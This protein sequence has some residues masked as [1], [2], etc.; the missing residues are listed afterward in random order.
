MTDAVCSGRL[1]GVPVA[2]DLPDVT[3]FLSLPCKMPFVF[4]YSLHFNFL[5]CVMITLFIFYAFFAWWFSWCLFVSAWIFFLFYVFYLRTFI[6]LCC[7]VHLFNWINISMQICSLLH[8]CF[9]HFLS[10]GPTCC[11]IQFF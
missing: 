4:I 8:A 5:A 6:T 10:F 1:T 3:N 7:V 2:S 9:L 11:V